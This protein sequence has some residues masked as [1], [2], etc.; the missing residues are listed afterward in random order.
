MKNISSKI[1]MTLFVI[2]CC[3]CRVSGQT[4]QFV[5]YNYDSQGNRTLRILVENSKGE[6]E[7]NKESE[8]NDEEDGD[9]KIG[10][11]V[12]PN[13]T[14]GS[15]TISVENASDEIEFTYSIV[16]LTGSTVKEGSFFDN[17]DHSFDI[18]SATA[19]VYVIVVRYSGNSTSLRI[20]KI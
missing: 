1:Y 8:S 2:L 11:K 4:S 9:V 19:G 3:Y 18:A 7:D 13:P 14:T 10:I 17:G 15:I 6:T 5:S 16:G 20:I 12:S